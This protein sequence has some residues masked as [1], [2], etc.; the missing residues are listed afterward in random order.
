VFD[1]NNV[2]GY[3]RKPQYYRWTT[4]IEHHF[5]AAPKEAP[6]VPRPSPQRRGG[7]SRPAAGVAR[8][9][10][11]R[12]ASLNP[13]GTPLAVEAWV[14]AERPDGVIL[15]HGGSRLGYVLFLKEGK[16]CFAVRNNNQLGMASGQ[17]KVPEGWVH[18]AGVLTKDKE[19]QIFVNGQPAGTGKAPGLI[20][21]DPS[22][23][24]EIGED[25]SSAVGDYETPFSF[26][27]VI[28]E[29]RVYHGELNADEISAHFVAPDR[30]ATKDPRLV[31]SMSFD[32]GDAKDESGRGNH[33]RIERAKAV[34]G[35]VGKALVF[36]APRRRARQSSTSPKQTETTAAKTPART[37]QAGFHVEHHWSQEIPLVVRAM[38]QAGDTLFIAGPPDIVDEEDAAQRLGTQEIQAKLLEQDAALLGQQGGLLWAVST[39]DGAKLA[40]LTLST[41]PAWDGMAA[42][43]G[44]LYMTM[45]DGTVRC[46]AGR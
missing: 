19:L 36:A 31:L 41:P 13:A 39:K 5:W 1:D 4:P 6:E 37:G 46:F 9:S 32:A 23:A 20:A 33:G 18:V 12:S 42:A 24:M 35:K 8:V 25:A 43:S 10:V 29:V 26:T 3:G 28:D 44:R 30:T 15:A 22:N 11:E 38:V 7:T 17:E 34:E 2:Y 16:P 40:E 27:G 21:E 14:R 45:T